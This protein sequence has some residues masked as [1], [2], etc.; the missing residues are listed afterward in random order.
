MNVPLK[1]SFLDLPICQ[2]ISN[3]CVKYWKYTLVLMPDR[4][5]ILQGAII[6]HSSE[7]YQKFFY[8][9]LCNLNLNDLMNESFVLMHS[10][11]YQKFLMYLRSVISFDFLCYFLFRIFGHFRILRFYLNALKSMSSEKQPKYDFKSKI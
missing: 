4:A 10:L 3:G 1:H 7:S 11:T 2:I 5:Q 8:T 9:I 6:L